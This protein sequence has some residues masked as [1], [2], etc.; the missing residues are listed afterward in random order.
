LKATSSARFIGRVNLARV[1]PSQLIESLLYD[2]SNRAPISTDE[3]YDGN[4][5][6]N[7]VALKFQ[8]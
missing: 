8:Q 1:R 6:K 2:E 7:A 4:R 5:A 3:S